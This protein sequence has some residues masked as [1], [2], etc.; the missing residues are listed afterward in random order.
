MMMMMM[1]MIII[2]MIII[3]I[4]TVLLDKTITAAHSVD[5]ATFTAPSPWSCHSIKN[6]RTEGFNDINVREIQQI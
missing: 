4:T 5:T 6:G 3:M 1:M 2:M